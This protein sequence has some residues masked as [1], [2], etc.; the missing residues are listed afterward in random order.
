MCTE[1]AGLEADRATT[2]FRYAKIMAKT[3]CLVMI[4]VY[5]LYACGYTCIVC[6]ELAYVEREAQF[7]PGFNERAI[8]RGVPRDMV[9]SYDYS[10][11][12]RFMRGQLVGSGLLSVACMALLNTCYRSLMHDIY[13]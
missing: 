5:T 6:K 2:C 3:T 11:D 4:A 13:G 8:E 1:I 9:L 10:D 7:Q 12:Q